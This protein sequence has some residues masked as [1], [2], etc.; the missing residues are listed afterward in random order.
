[1][2]FLR[3]LSG[4]KKAALVPARPGVRIG[5]LRDGVKGLNI[6]CAGLTVPTPGSFVTGAGKL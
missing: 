6:V 2:N 1:M 5:R 3:T 4:T